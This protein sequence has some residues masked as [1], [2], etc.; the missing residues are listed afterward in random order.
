M[1]DGK[2]I[3]AQLGGYHHSRGWQFRC[4]CHGDRKPSACVSNAGTVTCFAGC[5]REKV[6]A[7][8]DELGF[9]DDGNNRRGPATISDFPPN[10][11]VIDT[12]LFAKLVDGTLA[13]T[14]LRGR[15]IHAVTGCWALRF[16][17]SETN[18]KTGRQQPALVAT[19]FD[20]ARPIGVQLTFL[21]ASGARD[22]RHNLG[23]FG[24][25][26]VRLAMPV[27]GELGLAEGVET[28]LSA[29]LITGVACWAV[30][31]VSRFDK[32]RIPRG[33][34]RVHLFGD[35]DTPGRDAVRCAVRKY[36]GD[37][38]RVRAWWPPAER[39]DFNDVLKPKRIAA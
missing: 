6:E 22:I 26:A 5:K 28:A 39:G 24:H 31:G 17:P 16:S 15:G 38:L 25:G 34:K 20:G 21:H 4:P 12:W 13:E 27:G 37:G 35:N 7:K 32:V 11:E 29:T 36:T 3:A 8:L 19:V 9:T 14:Y 1:R 10:P 23:T 2:A 30:L 33:I 18:P